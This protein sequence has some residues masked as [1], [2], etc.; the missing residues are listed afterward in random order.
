MKDYEPEGS[1]GFGS[2]GVG[3]CGGVGFTG[4]MEGGG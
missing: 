4:G 1:A 3:S 2:P